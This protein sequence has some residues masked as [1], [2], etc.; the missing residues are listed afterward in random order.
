M[1]S[2]VT[3]RVHRIHDDPADDDGIRLLAHRGGPPGM[4][5][6]PPT[7]DDAP[8]LRTRGDARRSFAYLTGYG[9]DFVCAGRNELRDEGLL[10]LEG[11]GPETISYPTRALGEKGLLIQKKNV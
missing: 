4:R 7:P 8:T 5:K 6:E 3:V 10:G 1:T 9:P 2:S 11:V